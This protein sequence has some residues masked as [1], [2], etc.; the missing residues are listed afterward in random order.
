MNFDFKYLLKQSVYNRNQNAIGGPISKEL[1]SDASQLE[2]SY[3]VAG[4]EWR[5]WPLTSTDGDTAA[6]LQLFSDHQV[7]FDVDTS[8]ARAARPAVEGNSRKVGE[9]AYDYSSTT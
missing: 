3:R 1:F 7:E 8:R 4:E 9:S 2:D 6:L 5:E